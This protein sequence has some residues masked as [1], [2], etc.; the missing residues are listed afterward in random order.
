MAQQFTHFKRFP[1]PE[2][3]KPS[4]ETL[5]KLFSLSPNDF[6]D[7]GGLFSKF[8]NLLPRHPPP[9]V[10][11]CANV[12]PAQYSACEKPGNKACSACKLVSY[13]SKECQ[14]AHWKRHKRVCKNPMRSSDWQ[15]SWD[16][17]NCAPFFMEPSEDEKESLNG[18][19][20]LWGNMPA[21][22]LINLNANEANARKDFSLAFVA[23]GDL[24]HVMKTINSLPDDYSGKL[25]ILINDGNG[26]VFC[27]NL[28]LLLILGCVPDENLAAD[29]ALH[30]WYS[31][32]FPAE[33]RTRI[34]WLVTAFMKHCVDSTTQGKKY[35]LGDT[36]NFATP[37]LNKEH[38]SYL[39]HYMFDP[40]MPDSAGIEI[41][42]A[43][44]EYTRVR[45]A[46]SRKEYRDTMYTG[47]KPSHRVAFYEFRRYGIV[48]P[49]GAPNSHF[50][51]ANSSL[52]SLEG[53]W[54]QTD[55]ADPL[56]GWNTEEV[57]QSGKTHGAQVEDIYGCLYFFL[58]THLRTLAR[59][60]RKFHISFKLFSVE[61][62]ALSKHIEENVFTGM[63][64]ASN[65]RFDRVEV[66]NILDV[67]YVG[68]RQ[69]L[70]AWSPFLRQNKHAAIVGYY[71]NWFMV[72]KDG[73]VQGAGKSA[74]EQATK[75]LLERN[76]VDNLKATFSQISPDIRNLASLQTKIVSLTMDMDTMYENSKPFEK[77]L[78][79]EKLDTVLR[80]TKL[81][82]RRQHKI[83]PHVSAHC[84]A[85]R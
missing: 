73:R 3:E 83:V 45:M 37:W 77:Y 33:Y 68:T 63:G 31:V 49:L 71:M 39:Q 40:D 26:Y 27:R 85:S 30:F 69:V 22:D 7:I 61:A 50:N 38:R 64:I 48:L 10:L 14:T 82:L 58:S 81:K 29:I 36:S 16:A 78:K 43:Q 5:Q 60:I 11:P 32:F 57:I 35:P 19:S 56:E 44:A 28:V 9:A 12:Q 74:M 6:G 76:G 67:S 72:Q 1:P 84:S 65:T 13:C 66:S 24:R 34:C 62:C 25:D 75:Q 80:A 8:S 47:L 4:L 23:S 18:G 79:K 17:E 41:D 54:L 70:T 52:F 55:Y 21:I 53:R 59:R 15:P 20:A 2:S 51:C 42:D 46:P